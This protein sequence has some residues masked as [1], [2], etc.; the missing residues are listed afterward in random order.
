MADWLVIDGSYGEGGGQILRSTVALAAITGQAVRI[1]RIRAGRKR[2][3]MAAQHLTAVQAAA[4][5]CGAHLTGAVLGSQTLEFAPQHPVR[6]GHYTF[7]VAEA[8][9]GGSAGA[10]ILVLQ[11]VLLPLAL[12]AG[13]STVTVY[14]G[15]H[16]MA[17]PPFDY[18]ADV[19]LPMLGKMGVDTDLRLLRS[20]WYPL[21]KGEVRAN[22]C[23]LGAAGCPSLKPLVASVPGRLLVVMGRALAADLPAHIPQRMADRARSLLAAA[24]IRANIAPVRVSAANPGCGLSLAAHYEHC[25]AG[26]N[27]LGERGKPAE[28]VA[29]EACSMLLTHHGSG[30]ALDEHLADQVLLPAALAHGASVFSVER[31]SLHLLTHAWV[32]R[33]FGL[34]EV[35]IEGAEGEKGRVTVQPRQVKAFLQ[36]GHPDAV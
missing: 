16:V 15:T 35:V 22:I 32:V 30:T 23:G 10:A 33:C 28:R 12:A 7:D 11:T 2:P 20:G 5:L 19:W 21:G 34:A 25:R 24:G 26:F 4:T 13:D 18:A 6:P 31:I 3:G 29:E 14:G 36:P 27:V 9:E 8:R 1:E 17:S